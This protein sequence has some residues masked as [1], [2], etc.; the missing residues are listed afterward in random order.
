MKLT[1]EEFGE[2]QQ[3]EDSIDP[4]YPSNWLLVEQSDWI[5]NGKYQEQTYIVQD[6]R[7]NLYYRY[8]ISRSGSPF[9]DWYYPYQDESE[10]YLEEVTKQTRTITITEWV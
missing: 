2:V 1:S 10:H 7:T 3:A 6:I 5:Q 4:R 8:S 9:S